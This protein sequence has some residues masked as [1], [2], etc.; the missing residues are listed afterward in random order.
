MTWAT[1]LP[2][3][4]TGF[5]LGALATH[6][7]NRRVDDHWKTAYLNCRDR[8]WRVTRDEEHA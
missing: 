4:L 5:A 6:L 3:F 7:L 8:L 1:V 2:A